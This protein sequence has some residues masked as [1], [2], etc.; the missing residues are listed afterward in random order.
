MSPCYMYLNLM[1]LI[2]IYFLLIHNVAKYQGML[3]INDI[4]CN[5]LLVKVKQSYTITKV[6]SQLKIHQILLKN[7]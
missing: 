5:E 7:F 4:Y 2:I 1:K 6:Y 3:S